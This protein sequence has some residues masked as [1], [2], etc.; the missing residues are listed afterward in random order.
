MNFLGL[1]ALKD[2]S[3]TVFRGITNA[4]SGITAGLKKGW[5]LVVKKIGL[6]VGKRAGTEIAKELVNLGIDRALIPEIQSAITQLITPKIINFLKQNPTIQKWL[7]LDAQNRTSYYEAIIM[8]IANELIADEKQKGAFRQIAEGIADRVAS[9]NFK[10]YEYAKKIMQ[11]KEMV[12]FTDQFLN[13]F[14]KKIEEEAKKND[15]DK[16]K[17]VEVIGEGMINLSF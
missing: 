12:E 6:E 1:S 15:T 2:A 17:T 14:D 4:K 11:I 13:A 9:Q 5:G 10:I 16:I 8:R 3:K 7:K